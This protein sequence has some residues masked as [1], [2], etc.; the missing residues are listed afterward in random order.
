MPSK[1]FE[2]GP[3]R[4]CDDR[5]IPPPHTTPPSY[6]CRLQG[7]LEQLGGRAAYQAASQ[8]SVSFFNTSKWCVGRSRKKP[9]KI[10]WHNPQY[11]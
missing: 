8:L 9:P 7:S 1:V 2:Q 10:L 3:Y 11:P 6:V 5:Y 4:L